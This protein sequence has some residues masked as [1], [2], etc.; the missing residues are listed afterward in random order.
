MQINKEAIYLNNYS[1]SGDVGQAM[2]KKQKKRKS[3]AQTPDGSP[4]VR[5]L[6]QVLQY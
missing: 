3:D 4:N 1:K 5:K 2:E 6:Q